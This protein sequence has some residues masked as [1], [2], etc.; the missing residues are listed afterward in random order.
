MSLTMDMK[1]E[2]AHLVPAR[3][4]TMAA[5]AAVML[6]FAGGLHLVSGRII[7]E[8]EL[9]SP[10]VARRLRAFLTSLYGTES[11]VAVSYTHLTLPTICSV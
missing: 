8:A 5:E 11:S 2:L 1:E 9:D 4:S 7:I 3:Q 10:L 6:R